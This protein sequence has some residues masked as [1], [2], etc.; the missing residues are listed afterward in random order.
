MDNIF[1]FKEAC[2]NMI[3]KIRF[4]NMPKGQYL[5]VVFINYGIPAPYLLWFVASDYILRL[6]VKGIQENFKSFTFVSESFGDVL[7]DEIFCK[8]RSIKKQKKSKK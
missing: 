3:S 8:I 4:S 5:E 7:C 2:E 1:S 6:P